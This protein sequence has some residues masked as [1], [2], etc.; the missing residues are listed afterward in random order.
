MTLETLVRAPA[1]GDRNSHEGSPEEDRPAMPRE[2][3]TRGGGHRSGSRG[4]GTCEFPESGREP[5][6]GPVAA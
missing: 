3:Q 5:R 4:A 1:K 6:A 2:H